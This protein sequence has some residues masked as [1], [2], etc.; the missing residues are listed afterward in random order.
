M[1]KGKKKDV[2]MKCIR[3]HHY[4]SDAKVEEKGQLVSGIPL[5][6]AEAVVSEQRRGIVEIIAGEIT[7]VL[8]DIYQRFTNQ[9]FSLF[10]AEDIAEGL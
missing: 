1:K 6:R 4:Y 5:H 7:V 8:R 9:S 2:A 3:I 10:K